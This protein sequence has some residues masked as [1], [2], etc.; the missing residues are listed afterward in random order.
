MR[1][2]AALCLAAALLLA[3]CRRANPIGQEYDREYAASHGALLTRPS[4]FL[5]R[6]LRWEPPHPGAT[7][8]DIGSGAGRNSLHLARRGFHVTAVDLSSV[9]L[10]LTRQQ[11]RAARLPV[12]TVRQDIARFSIGRR[13][14]DLILLIDF[15][16]PTRRLLPRI[17]AGLKPGGLA[18][19]QDVSHRERQVISPDGELRYT[20][21]RRKDLHTAFAGFTILRDE[22]DRQPT[23][24][25]PNAIM[26]RFAAR[27]SR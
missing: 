22:Q 26:I 23:L 5:V 3:G 20:F 21:L 17:A 4:P 7:A 16:F 6:E 15:P 12:T 8:L 14:W 1:S 2:P 13:R 27:K 25:G 10:A 18:V 24:W 9:G 11:A 19:I